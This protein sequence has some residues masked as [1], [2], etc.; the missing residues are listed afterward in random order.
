MGRWQRCKFVSLI[1]YMYLDVFNIIEMESGSG[2]LTLQ[3][4]F[5]YSNINIL[6]D[7]VAVDQMPSEK[8]DSFIL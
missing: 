4:S 8:L 5:E 6:Q 1:K 7:S 2:G 3:L